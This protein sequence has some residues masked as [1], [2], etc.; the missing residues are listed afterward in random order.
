MCNQSVRRAIAVVLGLCA[1][2][3][4]QPAHAESPYLTLTT[5]NY[6]PF[7][8]QEPSTRRIVGISTDIVRELM[9]R[10]K[11]KYRMKFLPW[12][13]AYDMALNE[14]DTCVFSTTITEERKPL[15]KWVGPLVGND[16]VFFGRA[17][18]G[19]EINS[20]DDAREYTVGGYKGDAVA[21]YLE[22][23]GFNLDLAAHDDVNPKKLQA[24]RFELWASGN[25][26]GPFL[27]AQA[28]V[29]I[30]PLFTFRETQ[31][32]IACN[33][34]VEDD[35][36][37]QLNTILE[38]LRAEGALNEIAARYQDTEQEISAAETQ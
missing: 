25:H 36:I 10:A 15:F 4:F 3:V 17:G 30:T 34:S 22:Q 2:L 14:T 18:T 19:I 35:L 20:L 9:V 26:L 37:G 1:G 5:E 31:M 24:R 7:N 32:G 13:R 23:Q 8:M 11:V 6:P 12:Q 29:A 33:R 38:D 21:I 27:A 28:G 16:W